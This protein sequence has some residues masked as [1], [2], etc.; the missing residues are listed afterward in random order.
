M[1]RWKLKYPSY[2]DGLKDTL[3]E[4]NTFKNYFES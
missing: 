4:M 3:E 2:K 1:L